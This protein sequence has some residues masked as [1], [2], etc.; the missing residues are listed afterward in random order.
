MAPI[1]RRCGRRW[2]RAV[3]AACSG[4][5]AVGSFSVALTASAAS[6]PGSLAHA[7]RFRQ[8]LGQHVLADPYGVA[9]DPKGDVW[10]ADTGHDRIVEFAPSGRLMTSFS[11]RLDQPE[12]IAVDAAGH[13]WVADTGHDR[14]IEFSP[15]GRALATFGSPGTG[16]GELNQPVALAISPFG[17][18]WVADQGNSRVEEFS[19]FG[20]FRTSI[21]VPTPAGVTLDNHGDIWVSSPSYTAGNSVYEFSPSG[22]RLRSFGTTQAA[23]GDLGDTGGIAVGPA[24]RIFVAQ[25]DYG[26]VSVFSPSGRFYTE[27]GLQPSTA[28]AG[29]DLEFPQG[30]AVTTKDQVWVADSGNNRIAEFGSAPGSG[31]PAAPAAPSSPSIPLIVGECLLALA[32]VGLGWLLARRRPQAGP[33]ALSGR[34]SSGNTASMPAIGHCRHCWGDCP[35][36]CLLPG[37]EGRCIHQPFRVLPFRQRFRI[38]VRKLWRAMRG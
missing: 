3:A 5:L 7:P 15:T 30:L 28:N 11:G 6:G 8:A 34:T 26:L 18:V 27:F 2:S 22:M 29:E 21:A 25:P 10:V 20:R 9:L 23:H 12:G 14:V 19:A 17:D 36:D 24:G 37:D 4:L 32:L 16:R 13:V 31:A 1:Y 33:N 38:G 35:G